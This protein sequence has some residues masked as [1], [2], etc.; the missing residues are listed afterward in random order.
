[1]HILGIS[2]SL[3]TG[4]FNTALLRAA[5]A[6]APDGVTITVYDGLRTIPLYDEDVRTAGYP[7]EVAHLRDAIRAADGLLVATPEYNASVPG[8][9]KNAIDWAS[10]RPDQPMDGKPLGIMGATPGRSGTIRAQYH[11]R[12]IAASVNMIAMT[13]PEVWITG[14]GDRFDA[15]GALVDDATRV[16]VQRHVEA[17]TAWTR[18]LAPR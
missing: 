16:L 14:A 1:M 4:S 2:G 18:R 7:P 6:L 9:L 3:R 8:V 12:Q 5:A 10:R 15:A 17:L 11:L 13:T